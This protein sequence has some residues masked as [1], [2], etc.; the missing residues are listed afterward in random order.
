LTFN[1]IPFIINIVILTK[2]VREFFSQ[3]FEYRNSDYEKL[4]LSYKEFFGVALEAKEKECGFYRAEIER[5]RKDVAFERSRANAAIDSL[6]VR[7][8]H[9][10][11]LEQVRSKEVQAKDK[12]A[13]VRMKEF[14]SLLAQIGEDIGEADPTIRTEEMGVE[15]TPHA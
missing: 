12:I 11:P 3:L 6:L 8:A 1:K 10:A 14:D 9:I 4:V 2:G 15:I 5:L 7:D 13:Q